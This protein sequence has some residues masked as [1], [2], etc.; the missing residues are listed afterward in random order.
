MT[1]DPVGG[2]SLPLYLNQ[3]SKFVGLQEICEIS[4]KNNC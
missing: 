1:N 3:E 2:A 4:A